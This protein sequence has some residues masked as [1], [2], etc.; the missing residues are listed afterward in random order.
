MTLFLEA[1]KRP[2]E[3]I[4]L[5]LDATD[6]PLHGHQE[7]RFFHGY[8]DCYCYLPLY[9]FAAGAAADRPGRNHLCRRHLRHHQAQVLED[10]GAGSESPSAASS[11]PWPRHARPQTSGVALRAGWLTPPKPAP[12]PPDTRRHSAPI[13]RHHPQAHRNPQNQ[14]RQP[15]P[16]RHHP[17]RSAP[18][19]HKA[20]AHLATSS[21]GVRNAG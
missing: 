10:R 21:H 20:G 15:R 1:H 18:A 4:I 17:A 8:Y 13:A 9:V 19:D 2:P 16:R 7:G 5:D 12:R 14:N 11:S 6:D 3:Q